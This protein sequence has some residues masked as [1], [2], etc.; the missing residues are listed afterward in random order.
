VS[1]SLS[2]R[3]VSSTF[4]MC[5]GYRCLLGVQV[6]IRGKHARA[7][8][9]EA[10]GRSKGRFCHDFGGGLDFGGLG[11]AFF[12]ASRCRGNISSLMGQSKL[13]HG[14]RVCT[15]S[16]PSVVSCILALAD[17]TKKQV[18]GKHH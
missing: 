3:P 12:A 15:Y 7:S 18:E 17:S 16:K 5:C 6:F 11:L 13:Y 2:S 4:R 8:T 14:N 10:G 1:L 9:V